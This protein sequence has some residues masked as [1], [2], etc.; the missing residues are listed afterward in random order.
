[1]DMVRNNDG[2]LRQL[3]CAIHY[4]GDVASVHLLADRHPQL[5]SSLGDTKLLPLLLSHPDKFIC[6]PDP[7]HPGNWKV[8]LLHTH[9][10]GTLDDTVG[11]NV[12][13]RA[14]ERALETELVERIGKLAWY[15]G[16]VRTVRTVYERL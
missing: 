8:Q 9:G 4:Q 5:K 12:G 11:A 1:M 2:I 15:G 10:L 7:R 6:Q 3:A 14:A 13:F 16:M